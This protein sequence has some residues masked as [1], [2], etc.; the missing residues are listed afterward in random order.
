MN[1]LEFFK[2]VKL[3]SLFFFFLFKMKITL[4]CLSF[5]WR[6]VRR[7]RKKKKRFFVPISAF[8]SFT[9]FF[10]NAKPKKWMEYS[11]LDAKSLKVSKTLFLDFQFHFFWRI[12]LIEKKKNSLVPKRFV[13]CYSNLIN[14]KGVWINDK[15]L[16][17]YK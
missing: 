16:I 6:F 7:G 10:L 4:E 2:N 12:F 3:F 17:F 11:R 9:K 5:G 8:F 14:D 13:K 1:F 15:I